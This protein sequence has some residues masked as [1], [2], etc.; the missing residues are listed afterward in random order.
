MRTQTI[1]LV[2]D[3]VFILSLRPIDGRYLFRPL[4]PRRLLTVFDGRQGPELAY[5]DNHVI[6]LYPF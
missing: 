1:L 2:R 6:N 3:T 4:L 5:G